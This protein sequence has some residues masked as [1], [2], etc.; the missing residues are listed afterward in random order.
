VRVDTVRAART[1]RVHQLGA[2]AAVVC[3]AAM[4]AALD[5]TLAVAG[6]I[7]VAALAI[8]GYAVVR[9]RRAALAPESTT[10]AEVER[11]IRARCHVLLAHVVLTSSI[12]LALLFDLLPRGGWAQAIFSGLLLFCVADGAYGVRVDLPRLHRERST[13]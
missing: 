7:L 13:L 4:L 9:Q 5:P 3:V 6:S 1:L 10:R 8:G 11:R 12:A 2:G